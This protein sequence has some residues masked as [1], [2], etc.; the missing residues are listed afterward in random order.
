MEVLRNLLAR[1]E[2][3]NLA[4]DLKGGLQ[5]MPIWMQSFVRELLA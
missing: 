3:G 1:D 2:S 4:A 5:A